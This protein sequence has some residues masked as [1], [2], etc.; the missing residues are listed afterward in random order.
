MQR[1]V[2]GPQAAAGGDKQQGAARQGSDEVW[3]GVGGWANAQG[4]QLQ[5]LQQ[6]LQHGLQQLQ[7][8]VVIGGKKPATANGS[9]GSTQHSALDSNIPP[10]VRAG[11][12]KEDAAAADAARRHAE[13]AEAAAQQLRL[14]RVDKIAKGYV[15]VKDLSEGD[16][17]L[18]WAFRKRLPRYSRGLLPLFHATRWDNDAHVRLVL[19]LLPTWVDLETEDA[20]ELLGSNYSVAPI[21]RLALRSLEKISDAELLCFLMPLSVALRYDVVDDSSSLAA[22]AAAA[23]AAP[24]PGLQNPDTSVVTRASRSDNPSLLSTLLSASRR[25]QSS[26]FGLRV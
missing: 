13:D 24:R 9:N 5:Q 19:E 22:V 3:G 26:G 11:E 23:N 10:D 15:P 6:G 12:S 2:T 4:L 21:R 16:K 18:L 8:R 25:S 17:R 14:E 20:L 1:K 7:Q